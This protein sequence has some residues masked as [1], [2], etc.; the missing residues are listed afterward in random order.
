MTRLHGRR[1]QYIAGCRCDECREADREYQQQR[2]EQR[3]QLPDEQ[4]PHGTPKCY[5]HYE[6]RCEACTHAASTAVTARQLAKRR[7]A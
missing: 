6:C 4:K 2:R 1:S 5:T 3:R 7:A